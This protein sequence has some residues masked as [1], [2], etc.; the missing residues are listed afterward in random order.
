MPV[1]GLGVYRS[2][3]EDAMTASLAALK[4]GYRHIDSATL[5]RN[6]SG[7]GEAV[8]RSGIPRTD[9][10]ITSKI[11]SP[12]QGYAETLAA[13]DT[14]LAKL[15]M[16]YIDLYL[17]HDP[18]SGEKTRLDTYRALIEKREDE[19]KLRSI[20]VSNYG[21]RHL[22]EIVEAGFELPAV[23]QIELHPFCQQ[24]E[25]SQWCR[26]RG[27]VVQAYCPLMRMQKGKIDH[28]VLIAVAEKLQR[29]PT[30]ISIRWS[31]QKGFVPLPKSIHEERIIENA[32]VFAFDISETDMLALDGL[33]LGSSGAI[34]QNPVDVE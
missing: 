27:V 34:M 15:E 12:R 9:I 32:D 30:Q 19:G 6:E 8:R 1:L 11:Q 17:V 3:G 5:Y 4:H 28:P 20:G 23:N 24:R 18:R 14:S 26:A 25:I 7:V 16:D 22:E 10:F 2:F 21:L 13:V 31:L 29:T 33:D